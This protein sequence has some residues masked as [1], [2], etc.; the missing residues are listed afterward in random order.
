MTDNDRELFYIWSPG[1][2]YGVRLVRHEHQ[3]PDLGRLHKYVLT[4]D[5]PR[6][7]LDL[8]THWR[9]Q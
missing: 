5:G 1:G 2:S 3:C 8:W 4:F 6:F 9:K 7:D